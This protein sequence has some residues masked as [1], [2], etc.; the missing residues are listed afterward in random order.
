MGGVIGICTLRYME[1]LAHRDLC[2]MFCDNLYEIEMDVCTCKT[3]SL[4]CAAETITTTQ[5][6]YTSIRL[7]QNNIQQHNNSVVN[8]T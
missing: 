2:P 8:S 7:L 5:I 3:E 1:W 4:C 6:N